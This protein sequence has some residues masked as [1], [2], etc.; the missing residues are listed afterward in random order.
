MTIN[1]NKIPTSE[2]FQSDYNTIVGISD[3]IHNKVSSNLYS[4]S[5]LYQE[6]SA[7]EDIILEKFLS[8]YTEAKIINFTNTNKNTVVESFLT[9]RYSDPSFPVDK[10][11]NIDIQ[12]GDLVLPLLS[13]TNLK[14]GSVII[15]TDSNGSIGDSI[16]KD[17]ASN[18]N[19]VVNSQSTSALFKYDKLVTNLESNGLVLS[20][21]FKLTTPSI[22]NSI[23]IKLFTTDNGVY[24]TIDLIETSL[25]GV[26]WNTLNNAYNINKS[27]YYIRFYPVQTQYI[28]IRFK[29]SSFNSIK[30]LFGYKYQYLIGLR[31][32]TF[33][34]DQYENIG[35]YVSTTFSPG[36]KINSVIFNKTDISNN[37][38]T[39]LISANNGGKWIKVNGNNE[40]IALLDQ[41]AGV[42]DT[43]DIKNI[44]VKIVI[45]KTNSKLNTLTGSEL[46]TFSQQGKYFLK[47]SPLIVNATCGKQI[48]F[49]GEYKYEVIVQD[50]YI[51]NIVLLGIPFEIASLNNVVD[52][53]SSPMLVVKKDGQMLD[54][55]L[56]TL[57]KDTNSQ[58]T[59]ITFT[60][61]LFSG[62]ETTTSPSFN[63]RW[64][65]FELTGFI[66][67]SS[68]ENEI[69]LPSAS[70]YDNKN[71]FFI[72]EYI[73]STFTS[74]GNLIG[75]TKSTLPFE[76]YNIENNPVYN[77][78]TV[79][80]QNSY[81]K[82]NAIYEVK[83]IP[84]F[85][86]K[87]TLDI[88]LNEINIHA[89]NLNRNTEIRFDY[90]Y[91]NLYDV[92]LVKYYT[93]IVNE[94][95]VEMI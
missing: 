54:Q 94:Y 7:L 38:I 86:I 45:D 41:L 47:E 85:Q 81:F 50:S 78:A 16:L 27:D 87:N 11:L 92:N 77:S 35:E 44:R 12:N 8:L 3:N 72:T 36:K 62:Q 21:A 69:K 2:V 91:N 37:D 70:L 82:K 14:V 79:T 84:A 5:S 65:T 60:E 34:Q 68:F 39:Y 59:I 4:A 43:T 51:D 93:P 61:Q 10:R 29:Q 80:I 89:L 1:I 83:Y 33:K 19:S 75:G 52:G 15:E 56:Y 25:D 74:G 20:I 90:I 13:S 64:I 49:G 57:S 67:K 23:F 95:S 31:E 28:R 66:Y 48:S 32:I 73:G 26:K 76:A 40:T 9:T 88:T 55:S 17:D 58:N 30:T 6:S 46:H 42:L 71:E 18:I 63:N 53:I 24:P 22:L